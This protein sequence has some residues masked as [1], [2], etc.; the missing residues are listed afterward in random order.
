MKDMLQRMHPNNE[1]IRAFMDRVWNAGDVSA[2]AEFIATGYTTHSDPRDPWD[3]Q[4][5]AQH[6][7]AQRLVASRAAFPDL[8]FDIH[9][10]QQLGL[11]R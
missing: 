8:A 5:L 11:A 2:I 6:G 1:R 7:F 4:E 3:G 9:D 10:V